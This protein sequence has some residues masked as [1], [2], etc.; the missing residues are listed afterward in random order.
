MK[1]LYIV[2]SLGTGG[3]EK[4]ITDMLPLLKEKGIEVELLLLRKVESIFLG[5]LESANIK[6]H[7]SPYSLYSFKNIFFINNISKQFDL[8]HVHLFPSQYW[9]ALS[10]SKTPMLI[11]EHCTTNKRREKIIYKPIELLTYSKY[12]KIISI[13]KKAENSLKKWLGFSDEKFVVI[14]NGINLDTF[15]NAKP[16]K[17]KE[18]PENVKK[19]IMVGRFNPTKDQQTAIKAMTL[20]KDDVHLIL[21]GEGNLKSNCEKLAEDLK[22]KHKVHFLGL[23]N[24]VAQLLKSCDVNLISSHSEGLSISSLECLASGRPLVTSDV[25]GLREINKGAGLLF[26]DNNYEELA[27]CINRLLEDKDFYD[28]T[29]FNCLN[30]VKEYD[31][32]KTIDKHIQVYNHILEK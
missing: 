32:K 18:I 31:I 13:S 12:K 9:S 16:K 11:T 8:V 1:L 15:F 17:I 21:V 7:Y 5:P 6:I 29:V 30:R 20:L 22:V 23:R 14:E 28:D 2:N 24:D 19:V 3:A 10:F 26:E 25:N 27:S 4:L